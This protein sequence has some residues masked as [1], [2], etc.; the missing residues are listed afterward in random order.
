MNLNDLYKNWI[1]WGQ[2]HWGQKTLHIGYMIEFSYP[3]ETIV[4][5]EC[6]DKVLA[7]A[8]GINK[9]MRQFGPGHDWENV[10]YRTNVYTYSIDM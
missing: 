4:Q 1:Y 8:M 5:I 7:E 10:K 9:A 3:V 2:M 6:G